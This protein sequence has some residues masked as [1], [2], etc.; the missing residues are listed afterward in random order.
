MQKYFWG[1]K[2]MYNYVEAIVWLQRWIT[3][4]YITSNCY[5]VTSCEILLFLL[6]VSMNFPCISKCE[7][8]S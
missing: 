8:K 1:M 3:L 5:I 7:V 4:I 6:I 2:Q